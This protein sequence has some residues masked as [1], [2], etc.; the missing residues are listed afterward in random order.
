MGQFYKKQF[1]VNSQ[2]QDLS[3]E[4]FGLLLILLFIFPTTSSIKVF[5]RISD[6]PSIYFLTDCFCL[7][8]QV[9]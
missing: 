7:N 8:I 6:V 4:K 9:S 3:Y 1:V 2:T 5:Y